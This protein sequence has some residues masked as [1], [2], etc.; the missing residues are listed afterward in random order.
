MKFE[1]KLNLR[2]CLAVFWIIIGIVFCAVV[3]F[4]WANND[5]LLA[6]GLMFLIIGARRTIEIISLK[7]DKD[8]LRKREIQETDERNIMIYH[9]AM[10]LA[11]SIYTTAAAIAVTVCFIIKQEFIATIISYNI[12]AMLIIYLVCH[13]VLIRKY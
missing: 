8:K 7:K 13:Y 9:K 10:G 5:R 2:L 6:F 11:F 1:K 3:A 4:D 12:L